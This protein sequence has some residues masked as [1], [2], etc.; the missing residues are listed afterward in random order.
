MKK[1]F[2]YICLLLLSF[3]LVGC[4][5]IN[6]TDP[7]IPG[8]DPETPGDI[9][10]EIPEDPETPGDV[11]D[12]TPKDPENPNEEVEKIELTDINTILSKEPGIYKTRGTVVFTSSSSFI[13]QDETGFILINRSATWEQDVE[14]GTLVEVEGSTKLQKN[15]IQFDNESQYV[16]LGI[17]D[18]I[19]EQ[20]NDLTVDLANEILSESPVKTRIINFT[21][22]LNISGNYFNISLKD[23]NGITVSLQNSS[24]F[25]ELQNE[26]GRNIEAT[27]YVVG[28]TGNKIINLLLVEFKVLPNTEPENPNIPEEPEEPTNPEIPVNSNYKENLRVYFINVGQADCCLIMLPNGETVLIDAGLDHATSFGDNSFPSWNNI[29]TV[30]D[31]EKI[32]IINHFIIT[33]NH[34]DHYYYARD[35]MNKYSVKNVYMSGST[36]TNYAY[37]NIISTIQSKKINAV[38]VKVG[39]YIIN[40][41]ILKMQVVATQKIANP[42]DANFCSVVT[43]LT[44]GSKSF[45]FTGDAGYRA[46]DAE[47]IALNSGIN[48]KSDVLKVGHHGST[49]SSGNDFL[50][51]VDPEYAVITTSSITTTGHPH[52]A[53]LNRLRNYCDTILQSKNDGTVLFISNGDMLV[54]QTHI[55]E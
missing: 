8:N 17:S 36:S 51:A 39:D 45:L 49:Y 10:D 25:A 55:G 22:K 40:E 4:D 44:F 28:R 1:I 11:E 3:S 15:F 33:H 5:F 19:K 53:A 38:E 47:N 48:L 46:G 30:F 27:G 35:I 37:R 18:N 24:Q 16:Q 2:I 23:N 42:D 26:D 9:E 52:G 7:E 14:R 43:K 50:K 21:G 32:S 29:K 6:T 41:N 34:S 20:K 12:E 31:I 13:I 54:Y